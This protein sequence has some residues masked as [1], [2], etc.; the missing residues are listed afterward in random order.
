MET[1]KTLIEKIKWSKHLLKQTRLFRDKLRISRLCNACSASGHTPISWAAAHGFYEGVEELLSHGAP[2]GYNEDLVNISVSIIQLSY[3]IYRFMVATKYDEDES[4]A[5]STMTSKSDQNDGN[6][7]KNDEQ[8]MARDIALG[9]G[10]DEDAIQASIE[11][12]AGATAAQAMKH[13]GKSNMAVLEMII[14]VK[15]VRRRKLDKLQ[16]L[17]SSFRLPVPEALY[18]GKWEVMKRIFDRRLFHLKFSNSRVFPQ[19]PP[20]RMRPCRRADKGLKMSA[21]ECLAQGLSDIG[22]GVNVGGSVG[23]V[24]AGD[25]KDPFGEGV[26]VC[27]M[28]LDKVNTRANKYREKRRNKRLVT[29]QMRNQTGGEEEMVRAITNKDF[30]ECIRL[31]SVRSISIDLE[32][33]EGETALLQVCEGV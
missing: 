27:K 30:H 5:T 33:P 14:A 16:W 19:P 23:W 2:V 20:P 9:G 8:Q 21:I 6:D 7:T 3:R 22:A 18:N 10:G 28:I 12:G 31:A 29:I 15:E 26:E 32:T 25:E 1:E 11:A 4:L 13:A 24:G 17:R